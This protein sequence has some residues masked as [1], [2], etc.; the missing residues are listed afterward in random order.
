MRDS[1]VVL[2]AEDEPLASMALRAQME[3]LGYVVAGVARDGEETVALGR[4]LPVELAIVDMKMPGLSGLDAAVE[5]FRLA[6]TPVVLLTGFGAADLPASIPRPPIFA[7]LT[8]PVGLAELR[9]G[10]QKARDG[11]QEWMERES[12]AERVREDRE[13]RR[14]I[15]RAIAADPENTRHVCDA[16]TSFLEQAASEGTTPAALARRM[17]TGGG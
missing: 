8:K 13:A 15:A 14:L 2:I 17:A 12:A 4:C 5:L 3:A 10:I 6:P 1:P 11:F 7:I 9:T 16:A